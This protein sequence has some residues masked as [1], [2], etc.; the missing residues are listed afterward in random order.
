MSR[1]V[2]FDTQTDYKYT[3]KLCTK[4]CLQLR[5]YKRFRRAE[6]LS[7]YTTDKFN[8]KSGWIYNTFFKE[9]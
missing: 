8:K 6:V 9:K 7:L 4:Y 5:N 3:Y 1:N 2:K